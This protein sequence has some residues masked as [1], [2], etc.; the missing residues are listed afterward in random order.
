MNVYYIKALPEWI[1]TI[2]FKADFCVHEYTGLNM[3]FEVTLPP[4]L[5]GNDVFH[6]SQQ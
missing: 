3:T 6:I 2:L 1:C 5:T 4:Q